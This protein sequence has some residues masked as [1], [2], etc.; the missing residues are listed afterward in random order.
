MVEFMNNLPQI[1]FNNSKLYENKTLFGF[2]TN[3]NW[4]HLSWKNTKDL[5]LN[6]SSALHE[7]GVKKNDKISVIADNSYKWCAIDL[8]TISLGAITVPGYT[9]SNEEEISYLLSHSETSIVFV[10]GKLLSLI[11]NILP[12]L[13]KIKHV[14]CIDNTNSSKFKK[15]NIGFYTFNELLTLGSKSD[16]KSNIIQHFVSKIDENDVVSIIYTS[17]TSNKPKGVMLTHKSIISNIVGARELVSE[18]KIK[19]HKFL[20]IIPLS[21]AYEH[22][23]GFFLPIFIGAEIY[24]NENRDQIV[25]D[26][27][28]VKPTL[29]TAVPRLYE[30]LYKKINNQLLTKSKVSQKLFE[31]TITFGTKKYKKIK[32]SFLEEVQNIILDKLVRKNFQKKFGGNLQAFISGGAALNEQVGLFFQSLGINILQGYGQTE[33]SP[34]ISC[35]PINNIKIDTVGVVIKGLQVKISNQNEILVK[36]SSLMKGYWKDKKNTD[37]VLINGWLH[38]GDLGS[39]DNDG[40]LKISGRVNEM[41]VNSGGENIAPVPIE[42]LLLAYDEIE[43]VMIYGHN[44]PFL[45]AIII[46]TETTLSDNE[47]ILKE[48]LQNILN[49]VNKDLSQTKKIRKFIFSNKAFSTDNSQLTPTLKIRR[50]VIATYY[51]D[52]INNLYKKSFF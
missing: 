20:S 40:Y 38:T 29:M 36:G 31:K 26:L 1:F 27:I 41:I 30:V 3:N 28:S 11:L 18:I 43:Q 5:V 9:T 22:T 24:F 37:K 6:I 16:V 12:N 42:N 49:D 7:I 17:G 13:N 21:H 4:E 35:N 34:L 2:K 48:N 32:L 25:N 23:A 10:N 47:N 15:F 8:A 33:C 46:P 51:K 52:E 19:D 39:I 50:H 14:I 44:R 45:V